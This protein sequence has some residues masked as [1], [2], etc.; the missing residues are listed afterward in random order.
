MDVPAYKIA[1]FEVVDLPLLR[2]VARTGKP[3]L[4][5]TGMATIA[6]ISEA[7]STLR[8][9]GA[10]QIVLLK[11]TSAYPAPPESMNLRTIQYMRDTFRVPVGLSDHTLDPTV[12]VA[13]VA[14]GACVVEKHFTLSRD[15]GGPDAE[16]SLEPTELTQ[17][18]QAIRVAERA[19]GGVKFGGSDEESGSRKFR[20]SL[21]VVKD[22]ARGDVLTVEHVRSIRPAQGLPPK[23]L[24]EVLGK[25]A[26]ED[27][28]PGTP[29]A[30][31]H[32]A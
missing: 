2:L 4:M 5:S 8:Q 24:P 10:E 17:T 6:E 29:L 3:I 14:L 22:V 32:V 30:W 7:V 13:S 31:K 18:I 20:R 25:Q 9:A 15:A 11:C 12:P 26:A 27:I 28:P 16:F 23:H 19:L 1:S 21:F